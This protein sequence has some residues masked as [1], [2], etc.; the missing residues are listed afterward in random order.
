M[1]SGM[2]AQGK[3]MKSIAAELCLSYTTIVTYRNRVLEKMNMKSNTEIV[4]Y[5]VA[6]GLI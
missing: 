6:K 2:I 3:T 4:R 1:A 5:A